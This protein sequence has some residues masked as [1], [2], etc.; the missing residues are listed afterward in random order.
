M[1]GLQWKTLL[2]WMIWGVKTPIFGNTHILPIGRW[3]MPPIYHLW[4]GNQHPNHWLQALTTRWRG[5]VGSESDVSLTNFEPWLIQCLW[6]FKQKT[7]LG[8]KRSPRNIANL[9]WRKNIIKKC[10]SLNILVS[11]VDTTSYWCFHQR[12]SLR[13]S[14]HT[15]THSLPRFPTWT[16]SSQFWG[17]NFRFWGILQDGNSIFWNL[18]V[19][20]WRSTDLDAN[21]NRGLDQTDTPQKHN[22]HVPFRPAK[23]A[24]VLK[25][26]P[27]MFQPFFLKDSLWRVVS[28]SESISHK[29]KTLSICISLQ[30][31][32]FIGRFWPL[33]GFVSKLLLNR[34]KTIGSIEKLTGSKWVTTPFSGWIHFTFIGRIITTFYQAQ[35]QNSSMT[36]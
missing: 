19:F 26:N 21:K 7:N 22:L 24:I 15:R 8:Q 20:L 36:L 1:D 33:F 29:Y 18:C 5:G 25:V 9:D 11:S 6:S 27:L 2:K 12:W 13:N 4:T 17:V 35:Q 31:A 30:D 16:I 10:V 32:I 28:L 14:I 3:T 23:E 34:L